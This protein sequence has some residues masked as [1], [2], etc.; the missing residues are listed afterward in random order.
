MR[1]VWK[2]LRTLSLYLALA[3]FVVF[4]F[5]DPHLLEGSQ[6][7]QNGAADPSSEPALARAAGTD[8]FQSHALRSFRR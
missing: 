5:R 3:T 8:D 1:V 7:G 6:G 4:L 2:S